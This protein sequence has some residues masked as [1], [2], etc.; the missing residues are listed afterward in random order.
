MT[1]THPTHHPVGR[2]TFLL[3]GAGAAL[4]VAGP[5]RSAVGRS[6]A[7]ARAS[8]VAA[9]ALSVG[10]FE[11]TPLLDSSGPFFLGRQLAFPGATADDWE[12]ARAL[13]PTA[14]G[15]GDTWHLDFRCYAV[16]GPGERITLVDTGVGPADSPAAAWAPVP[17]RL[18]EELLLA[19]IDPSDVDTVVLSHLHEDHFGWSV[20]AEGEPRFPNARYVVQARETS[21]LAAGDAALDYVV[22]PLRAAG[23]L[24]EVSGD[25]VLVTAPSGGMVRVIPTPGHTPGHQSVLVEHSG[26]QVIVTGDVL[27]HAVQ[28]VDPDVAYRYEA[29]PEQARRTRR[30]L[31][32]RARAADAILATA[33]LREPFLRVR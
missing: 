31:L 11:V 25:D 20:T 1:H 32:D 22:S 2:R 12:Q 5:A 13:D 8:A 7:V 29:Q 33:H 3:A 9:R 26:A 27:V 30:A 16:R 21:S 6:Q 28:L 15:D 18:P 23:L 4:A 19:G 24:D 10:A 17:G 14:F